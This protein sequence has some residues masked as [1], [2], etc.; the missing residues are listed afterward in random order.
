MQ[1]GLMADVHVLLCA[2]IAGCAVAVAAEGAL[3]GSRVPA[4]APT[5][6]RVFFTLLQGTWFIQTARILYGAFTQRCSAQLP[7]SVVL[8]SFCITRH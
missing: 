7:A 3:A 1:T 2:A 8:T 4:C 6:A 5:A